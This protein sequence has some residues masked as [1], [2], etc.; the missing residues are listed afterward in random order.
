METFLE[1]LSHLLG[2]LLVL[3]ALIILWGLTLLSSKVM[4]AVMSPAKPAA[5][6]PAAPE[7]PSQLSD[8]L[9]SEELAAIAAAVTMMISEPSRIVSIR[10]RNVDWSREGRRQHHTSHQVR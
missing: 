2:F 5:P 4:G 7:P 9:G 8:D 1:A 10:Q 6:A 3:V